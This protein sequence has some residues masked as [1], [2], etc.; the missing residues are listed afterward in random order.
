M[1]YLNLMDVIALPL[2]S[3]WL[4]DE[5]N[6]KVQLERRLI[7][8]GSELE[9]TLGATCD[10]DLY[11]WFESSAEITDSLHH[12][13]AGD[14]IRTKRLRKEIRALRLCLKLANRLIRARLRLPSFRHLSHQLSYSEKSWRLLHG[15][16]P[17]REQAGISL[18]AFAEVGGCVSQVC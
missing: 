14:V 18:P 12:W 13:Y 1:N 9:D 4:Y 6:G 3:W 16:H 10:A 15:A 7:Q 2:Q 8:L 17:P 11:L 5:I